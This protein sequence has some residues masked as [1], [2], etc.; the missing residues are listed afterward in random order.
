MKIV[1]GA[2]SSNE[3]TTLE[4][5]NRH[6][7]YQAAVESIVLLENNGVLPLTVGKIA[8][9]GAGA[10]HTIKGGTGSGEVNE[11]YS[12][13]IYDGLKNAGFEITTDAW[14]NEYDELLEKTKAKYGNDC[15]V[16]AEKAETLA[17]LMDVTSLPFQFPESRA[18]ASE[19]C[20]NEDT[21]IYIVARQAGEANDKKL[22]NGDFNLTPVELNDLTFLSEYYKN[23]ILV[24]NSGSMMDLSKIDNLNIAAVL[25]YCQQGEEGGNAFAD[26]ICGKQ[27]PSGKLTDTW[28]KTYDD[29]PFGNEYSYLSGDTTKEY[30]RED[31]Y[32]GYR[33]FDT[34]GVKP[35]YNFG[36]GLSYTKFDIKM[37]TAR[38]DGT[39]VKMSVSVKNVGKYNGKE[40]I[41]IYVSAPEG[42]INKEYQRLIAFNKTKLLSPEEEQVLDICFDMRACASY[43]E[44]TASFVLERGNYI[45]RMG[46]SSD[47]TVVT[48]VITLSADAIVSKHKNICPVKEE[49]KKI[50]PKSPVYN[51][52]LTTAIWLVLPSE[53]IVSVDI[54]YHIPDTYSDERVDAILK[55]LSVKDMINLCVGSGS[56]YIFSKKKLVVPGSVGRTTNKLYKKGLLGVHLADGPAGLRLMRTSAVS[57]FILKMVDY[58]MAFVEYIPDTYK[59]YIMADKNSPNI[60]YQFCT[61]FPVGTALAQTWNTS[62]CEEIGRAISKEMVKYNVTFWLAPAMNIHRNPLCGRNFEYY[63]EDPLLTGVIASAITT[64][65]QSVNGNYAT[66]KHF[67]CNNQEDNRNKSDSIVSERALR[68]IYLR[69]FEI[70][71][72]EAHPK[73][74]MTSYNLINGVYACNNN[75][76]I[77]SV[78]RNEWGFDGVVMTDWNATEPNLARNDLAIAAGN[79]MIMPGNKYCKKQI[80][81]GLKDKTLTKEQLKK[82][83]ANIIRAILNSS[84]A[85]KFPVKKV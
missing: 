32:V 29:I 49:Y 3:E 43:F 11:R 41:Q 70:C 13:S 47:A 77:G 30:Y 4:K 9:F 69:G 10:K 2:M 71:V 76:L 53:S 27:T 7:A 84:V 45:V 1:T 85:N 14:L 21:A 61:A 31:I 73:A 6:I 23:V 58:F 17:Q 35:R 42:T 48:A 52:D 75:D 83:S 68:E 62:L 79:D 44:E 55:R 5:E 40:T 66:I 16:A 12:V 64:G 28:V 46:N 38:I 19:D 65:I 80:K 25:Y 8:L 63:S 34:F 60:L 15:R 36:Y 22:E 37:L 74:L 81:K 67:A 24:I 20:G 39:T 57:K 56:L 78:L 72:K 82:A 51:D 26:I 18:I 59:K 50:V 54:K 33:Y